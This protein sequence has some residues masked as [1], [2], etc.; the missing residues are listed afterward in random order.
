[1]LKNKGRKVLYAVAVICV[2][3]LIL[4]RFIVPPLMETWSSRSARIAEL[5]NEID[6]AEQLI[7]RKDTLEK[8]WDE[9]QENAL[10]ADRAEAENGILSAVNSWAEDSRLAVSSLRPRWL[11]DRG[12]FA[13]LEVQATA[14]GQRQAVLR[15]LHA[16]ETDVY[17]IHVEDVKLSSP[18]DRGME[19]ALVVRFT[20]LAKREGAS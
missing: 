20:A 10:P 13:K 14:T 15:F 7:E 6:R 4:D 1:M 16:L 5:R 8:R 2:A 3:G 11:R 17:P 12:A 18:D 9:M 19:M